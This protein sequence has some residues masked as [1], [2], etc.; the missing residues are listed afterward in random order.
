MLNK[1]V[2]CIE[3]ES[4]FMSREGRSVISHM[5]TKFGNDPNSLKLILQDTGDQPLERK[6]LQ[7]KLGF[8]NTRSMWKSLERRPKFGE[9]KNAAAKNLRMRSSTFFIFN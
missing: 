9:M 6:F 5:L 2:N 8:S 3:K 7:I 1:C 4:E